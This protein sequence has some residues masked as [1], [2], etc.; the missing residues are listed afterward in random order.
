MILANFRAVGKYINTMTNISDCESL[1][2]LLK[3]SEEMENEDF[4]S[5]VHGK[6]WR[7]QV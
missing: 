2:E 6:T 5:V 3:R 7:P 4:F 1:S